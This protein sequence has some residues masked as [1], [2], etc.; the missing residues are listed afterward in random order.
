MSDRLKNIKYI[1]S[2]SALRVFNCHI[3]SREDHS[4]AH[5][6]NKG[7]VNMFENGLKNIREFLFLVDFHIDHPS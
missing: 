7:T 2:S 4:C 6:V 5:L 1:N 3:D